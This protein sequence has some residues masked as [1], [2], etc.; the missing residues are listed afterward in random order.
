[1]EHPMAG[2]PT[3]WSI[4]KFKGNDNFINSRT[5]VSNILM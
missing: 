5:V 3:R 2:L 4:Q 1:M